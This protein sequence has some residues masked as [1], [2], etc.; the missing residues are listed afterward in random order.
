MKTHKNCMNK[1]IMM[2]P[3]RGNFEKIYFV[4]SAIRIFIYLSIY[5]YEKICMN[6][7]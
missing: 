7:K 5:I 4:D 1:Y 6:L 2:K 3:S